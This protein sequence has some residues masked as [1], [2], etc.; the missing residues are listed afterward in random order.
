M[1]N[2]QTTENWPN[3][4]PVASNP[5]VQEVIR[6]A[7]RELRQLIEERA[8]V[9]KRIGTIKKTI[10]G[11]A[12]LFGDA[13]IDPALLDLVGRE[14]GSR[15]P[16][17]TRACRRVLLEAGRPLSARDVCDQI[18]ETLPTLL[19]RHKDPMATIYT[20]LG[21]LVEYGEVTM[22]PGERGQRAWVWAAERS[23]QAASL[24]DED[25]DLEE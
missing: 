3:N 22:L 8:G 19:A 1:E 11:L 23:G 14:G 10:V 16:G 5:H 12:N 25:V 6:S 15:Q 9:T 24:D 18:Q 21:R 17:I 2:L 13:V 4:T 20:I 7:E